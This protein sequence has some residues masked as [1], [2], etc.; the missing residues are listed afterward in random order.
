MRRV[1]GDHAKM[2]KCLLPG[3]G[4]TRVKDRSWDKLSV[5]AAPEA[6]SRL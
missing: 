2:N 4:K 6:A 3:S 5:T 1:E